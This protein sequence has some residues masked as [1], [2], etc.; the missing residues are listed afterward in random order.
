MKHNTPGIT[1][2]QFINE[3]PRELRLGQWFVICYWKGSDELSQELFQADGAK[4]KRII[5]QLMGT[6]QWTTLPEIKN[7]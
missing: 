7:G 1:L 2:E 6:W 5:T 4:A 3:K